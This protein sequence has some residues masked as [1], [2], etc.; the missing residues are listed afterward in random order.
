MDRV[1]VVSYDVP[2]PLA[3]RRAALARLLG[4]HGRRVLRSVFE[5]YDV[6][7]DHLTELLRSCAPLLDGGGSMLVQ[8][9]CARCRCSRIGT[10]IEDWSEQV[11]IR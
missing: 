8:P 4:A 11:V 1:V 5:L 6:A 10:P 3:A 9:V 2:T 7:D